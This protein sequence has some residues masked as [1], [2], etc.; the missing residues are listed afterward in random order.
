M[1]LLMYIQHLITLCNAN[2]VLFA[3]FSSTYHLTDTPSFVSGKYFVVFDPHCA[4]A[5]GATPSQPGLVCN[6]FSAYVILFYFY[7]LSPFIPANQCN[8]TNDKNSI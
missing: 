5:P 1:A 3:G 8:W 2:L 7:S 4:Y 6:I